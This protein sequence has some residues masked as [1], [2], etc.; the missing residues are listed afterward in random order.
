MNIK[1]SPPD[2]SQAEIDEVVDTLRSGWI[3]TGPKTKLFE[4]QIA[5]FCNT[6]KAV[7]L[8]SATAG[9]EL[10]LRI[11]GIGKGDEVITSAYTYTASA[12]VIEHVG[13]KIM[14]C[15]MTDDGYAMAYSRLDKLVTDKTK[16]A[17]FV[18]IPGKICDYD[19]A[20]AILE[21]KKNIFHASNELQSKIG[22][23]LLIADAA[24][25]FG[26]VKDGKKSGEHADFT[27]FSFHAV[28]NLTTAEGGAV[29]WKDVEGVD[30]E[31][32]YRQF[33][34][35]S[36]HGQSKDALAKNQLGA[37]EYDIKMCGQKCN[38]TDI[39]AAIG[40]AQMKRYPALLSRRR[41]IINKYDGSLKKYGETVLH[42][43]ENFASSGHL[44]LLRV[45][46]IDEKQRNAIIV[47]MAEKGVATNV[48]YKPLPM[49]TAYKNL[50]FDINDYPKAYEKY[51]NE[52][53]LPLHTLLTD[54]EVEYVINAFISS[55]EEVLNV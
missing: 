12:S 38:M 1:F 41:E 2:I 42:Y 48:H 6:P 26:A 16:A 50:G 21:K 4:R 29:V 45:D 13:A 9:L 14:L 8:N 25:S 43:G 15:D 22:R 3:T 47:K 30:N 33:M 28:K 18:G 20:R 51:R 34:L 36:L 35:W 19:R 24:H 53:T 7:C 44:Y 11:F 17:M 39:M 55:A 46:G 37:W 52:I 49:H 10:I 54:E 40:L 32:L 31:E 5:E 23:V 27:S